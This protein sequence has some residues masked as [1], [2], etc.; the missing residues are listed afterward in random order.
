MFF[1]HVVASF[2]LPPTPGFHLFIHR[3]QLD[4]YDLGTTAVYNYETDNNYP[5]PHLSVQVVISS[6]R[7][8]GG[9][10]ITL[11]FHVP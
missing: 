5:F 3:I 10:S 9:V 7:T 8:P 4:K 6:T 1:F 11:K 2:I